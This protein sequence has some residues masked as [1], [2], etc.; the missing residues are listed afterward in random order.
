M[1]KVLKQ[2]LI[3]ASILIALAVI[4]LPMLFDAPDDE[5]QSREMAIELPQPAGE[6]APVRRMPLDP[7]QARRVPAESVARPTGDPAQDDEPL[8]WDDESAT[9]DEPVRSTESIMAEIEAQVEPR[10]RPDAEVPDDSQPDAEPADPI[11]EDIRVLAEPE[12]EPE[13]YVED[14]AVPEVADLE[15]GWLVQVATFS[16]EASAERMVERLT[17]LGHVAGIDPF[18]RG[19]TR[20]HRVRVGP[21][22]SRED[23]DRSRNQ[24]ARTVAGVDPIVQSGPAPTSTTQSAREAYVVQVG[25]F[26]S[27]N[28]AERLLGQLEADRFEAFIHEDQAGSRTIW[29]VRVG[30]AGS[31]QGAEQIM[32]ELAERSRLEGMVVSHP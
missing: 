1:D 20:L 29:R 16:A 30:P 13:A 18:V 11:E 17:S 2:R 15:E 19:D 14:R 31:R 25:S 5:R 23:A 7:E 22:A 12:P 26:A 8:G 24:I 9:P 10:T 21:Y 3:G 28:N 27:R 4:F 32:A 6:R